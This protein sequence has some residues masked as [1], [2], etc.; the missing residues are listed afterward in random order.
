MWM[1]LLAAALFAA[2]QS[3]KY[4]SRQ[5]ELPETMIS[6]RHIRLTH[7]ENDGL[8]FG[9]HRGEKNITTA[10]PCLSFLAMLAELLPGIRNRSAAEKSGIALILA[11]GVSNIFDRLT[12]GSVT[13]Y[14]QFP[15]LP[16]KKARTL[17]WNLADFLL[18]IGGAIVTVCEIAGWF[19]RKKK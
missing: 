13:D 4:L 11:G 7:L 14:I 1:F 10:V 3:L 18:L 19:R 8:L 5:N 6:E 15:H 16:W 9:K 2:D 17:V 12:R